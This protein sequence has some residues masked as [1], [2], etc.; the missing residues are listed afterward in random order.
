MADQGYVWLQAKV[1]EHWLGLQPRLNSEYYP[2][3]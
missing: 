2:C 3:L 1:C